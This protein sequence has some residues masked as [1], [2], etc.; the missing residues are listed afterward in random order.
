MII[1]GQGGSEQAKYMALAT[2][3]PETG[4]PMDANVVSQPCSNAEFLANQLQ[5]NGYFQLDDDEA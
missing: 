1:G 5:S 4:D 3:D 2:T